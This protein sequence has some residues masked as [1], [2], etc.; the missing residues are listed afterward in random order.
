VSVNK[1]NHL[2]SPED[3]G[4]KRLGARVVVPVRDGAAI[5]VDTV[6]WIDVQ[7]RPMWLGEE[8]IGTD[9]GPERLECCSLTGPHAVEEEQFGQVFGSEVARS[10]NSANV[11]VVEL[12]GSSRSARRFSGE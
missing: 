3:L 9:I 11:I 7:G 4:L 2:F 6:L 1:E 10:T 8:T 12:S 5:Q